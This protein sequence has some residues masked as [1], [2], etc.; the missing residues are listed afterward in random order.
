MPSTET[1]D[2][3]SLVTTTDVA[4]P[5]VREIAETIVNTS[6]TPPDRAKKPES[7]TP[8]V[9][10]PSTKEADKPE[11]SEEEKAKAEKEKADKEEAEKKGA[12]KKDLKRLG[13]VI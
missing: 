2:L 13:K 7:K 6:P 3:A 4:M 10:K 12:E 11:E 8:Q 1:P 5:E 9:E